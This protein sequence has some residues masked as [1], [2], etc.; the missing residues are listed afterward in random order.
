MLHRVMICIAAAALGAAILSG[1]TKVS[2]STGPGGAGEGHTIP[3]V[4]RIGNNSEPDT[5][6]PVI[7]NLQTDVDLSMF[8]GGYL[9]NWTDDNK[10]IG[11][12][13][14]QVP[15]PENGGISKDGLAVTY[16][17]RKGVHWQDGPL[18]TADDVIYTWQQVMNPANN[19]GSRVG[20]D[21]IAG[22]DKK[23]D[24]TIVVHLKKPFAPFV[25]SFFTMSGN[26]YP[27]LPKHLLSQYADIN[28]ADF[29]NKPVGTGPFIVQ[30]WEKGNVIVMVAN[31]NYWRGP[32]KLKKVEYHIIPNENTLLTQ[33]QTHELDFTYNASSSQYEELKNIPG[34]RVYLTAFT[35]Y[36]QLGINTTTPALSDKRVRQAL[37][38]A[39]D[40][41]EIIHKISHD[42]NIPADSDQPTFLWAYNKNVKKYPYDIAMAGTL[43]DAAGWTMGSDGYRHNAKGEKLSVQLTAATGRQDSIQTEEI[44]QAQWRKVGVEATIKDYLS[45]QLF[46]SYGAGGI[47]QTGKFEI[48]NYS[49]INGVDPDN[50]TLWMC[51]Q[52]PSAGVA[53]QNTYR[54]CD[55]QIDAAERIALT[56][57]DQATRKKA[58]DVISDRLADLQPAIFI[59]FVR[60]ID[61]ANVDFKGYKPAHAVTQFWNTWEYS[62]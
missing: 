29:N 14:T 43:L 58:Y 6:N 3:G 10:F 50:S 18:F 9:F 56:H 5:M 2:M 11:E 15:T 35:Q 21:V 30:S 41:A 59:W 53:G 47:Y 48:G 51:D 28:H 62:I 24:Y 13:A 17:L 37:T 22:I 52:I 27:I 38:Y 32:P 34:T 60:R 31:P 1:C 7:G 25:A 19:V 57:Y 26:P 33:L 42:V 61:I 45:P 12:L 49:W 8:W 40:R 46:A 54:I 20:Y 36:G 44:V 55:P 16:H 39:T 23:D 4:L